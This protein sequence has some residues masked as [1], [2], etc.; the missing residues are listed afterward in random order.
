MTEIGL[1]DPVYPRYIISSMCFLLRKED[2]IYTMTSEQSSHSNV[3]MMDDFTLFRFNAII[4]EKANLAPGKTPTL[5]LTDSSGKK[6]LSF[7]N[8]GQL[9]EIREQ[10]ALIDAGSDISLS[11]SEE[12]DVKETEGECLF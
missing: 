10:K 6:R 1:G 5:I 3:D 12:K 7:G 8:L 2:K 9:Q 11:P 4:K